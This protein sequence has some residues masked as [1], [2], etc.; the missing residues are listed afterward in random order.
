MPAKR[1]IWKILAIIALGL[2]FISVTVIGVLV[3]QINTQRTQAMENM[4]RIP[5]QLERPGDIT[6]LGDIYYTKNIDTAKAH[7]LVFLQ[8]GMGG[9]KENY[10]PMALA[11]ISR[12]FVVVTMNLRNHYG[13]AG[14]T[15]LGVEESNDLLAAIEY[16]QIILNQRDISIFNVG[17]VGHSL[18]ALTSTLAAI[19][20]NLSSCV[21]IAPPADL[22]IMISSVIGSDFETF[23]SLIAGFND[24]SDPGFIAN[25]T[26]MGQN[27]PPNYLM[28]A[29]E[30]DT[31]VK[32][33]VVENLLKDFTKNESAAGFTLYGDFSSGTAIEY[34]LLPAPDHGA[35][36][37]PFLTPEITKSAIN[38]T[39]TALG[40]SNTDP[41]EFPQEMVIFQQV[42]AKMGLIGGCWL[43]ILFGGLILLGVAS[44]NLISIG[45]FKEDQGSAPSLGIQMF[46]RDRGNQIW[47]MGAFIGTGI[48]SLFN[49]HFTQF[50]FV[51]LV[52]KFLFPIAC[53]GLIGLLC[54]WLYLAKS[55]N[56]NLESGSALG[57]SQK[58]KLI[59]QNSKT[60]CIS[61]CI[62][63]AVSILVLLSALFTSQSAVMEFWV[64]PLPV[65]AGAFS[66]V[67]WLSVLILAVAL[68]ISKGLNL[69]GNNAN[70]SL[71]ASLVLNPLLIF[72]FS[73]VAGGIGFV[74]APAL[75]L[76]SLFIPLAVAGALILAMT[77]LLFEIVNLFVRSSVKNGLFAPALLAP[78]I[79]WLLVGS[80]L[81]F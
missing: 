52:L 3:V 79:G 39:E 62:G 81:A 59:L 56:K 30:G 13:S 51:G 71:G 78:F 75:Q 26:L 70:P 63:L 17:I 72:M 22:S 61:I 58:Y 50:V 36:Q 65:V 80:F 15:T 41:I 47:L 9:R 33:I 32:P 28:I 76:G 54:K 25:F 35:E 21:A 5:I 4:E 37:Y 55:T 7:P 43:L 46:L 77:F 31:L 23:G 19:K 64:K 49:I 24:F 66:A 57:S 60:F 14:H 8:H 20:G 48:I 40:I 73:L 27:P 29:G 45:L 12:G 68:I 18:G 69:Q 67:F 53:G 42:F 44:L 34:Q 1:K 6:I 11:F 16:V 2:V 10:Q 74:N 38:W